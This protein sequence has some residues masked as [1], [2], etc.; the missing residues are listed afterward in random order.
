MRLRLAVP[1]PMLALLLAGVTWADAATQPAASAAAAA[2]ATQAEPLDLNS[3]TLE[4]LAELPGI[5]EAY[6]QAIVKGR[7]YRAK[8]D[9]VRRKIVPLATY[10]KIKDLV[11]ARHK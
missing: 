3:A 9:L 4:Q 2:A 6:S 10:K 1:L 7:P 8:D 11:I 5:G